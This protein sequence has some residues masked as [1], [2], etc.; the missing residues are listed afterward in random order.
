MASYSFATV[1]AIE[2]PIEA[3]WGVLVASDLWPE[4]WPYLKR[5]VQIA[6]GDLDGIGAITHYRWRGPL[7]YCL[8]FDMIITRVERPFNLGGTARGDLEGTG[9]WSLMGHGSGTTFVRY[10]WNVR[11]TK[12]WM[13]LM[14]PIARRLFV[15]N[16]DVIM[17]AGERGLSH[18]LGRGEGS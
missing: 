1:W 15:W 17:R 11:T 3:V 18:R 5:V 4:W 8:T 9:L 13:N 7:P 2:A 14:A 6:P 10:D 12:A 16:H